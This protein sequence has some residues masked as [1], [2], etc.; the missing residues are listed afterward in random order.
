METLLTVD[1]LSV[2]FSTGDTMQQVTSNVS[3]DVKK[4]ETIGIVGESGS[5]KSVTAR[6]IMQLLAPNAHIHPESS[7][8]FMDKEL[9]TLTEKG[10]RDIRGNDIGMIF[11]DPMTSLNP[12]MTIGDQIT[13][14]LRYHEKLSKK[15]AEI[16]AKEI[17]EQVGITKVEERY[18]QYAHEFSGGMRQR[19]MI[20][21]ALACNPALLIADEPTTALDV[22]IQAQIL[23]LLKDIQKKFGTSII[24]IT[25]DFG[26]VANMC[27]RV[28]VMKEGQVVESGE[29]QT[30]FEHPKKDYTKM[31]LDAIPNLHKEKSGSHKTKL[32]EIRSGQRRKLL[33]VS[34]LNKFFSLG[35]KETLKAVNDI[36]FS[37]YEGETL[38]LVGESGSGKSTTGRTLLRLHEPT[39]GETIYEGFDLNNLSLGEMKTMRKHI[40]MIFQDPYASLNPRMKIID[41]I[42]EA[43]DVHRLAK[44]K[45]ERTERILELLDLVGLDKSFAQRYP[46][47][48][49]GGQ[50]QR[51]GIARA[52]A[53]DPEF[54]V[55]DEPLSALDAS[56]Q[57]QIVDLLEELQT[58][59]NLT[60]LFIAHDLAMVKQIS[61]RVAVMYNGQ[62]VE[63]AD[64]Q[65]LFDNPI[66]PY[67]RKLLSAIPVP[68]PQYE[69][70]HES[71]E[72]LDDEGFDLEKSRFIEISPHHWV[73]KEV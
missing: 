53:V 52:L 25:H 21:L 65:E 55:L 14:T 40:Q 6:S 39:S 23:N 49:S 68:D 57:I 33:E 13:E 26:V 70:T 46:H 28:I 30:V 61:D 5:G 19:M 66:H 60:Y 45:K 47:E 48:F 1:N 35:K 51:I 44:N 38:G 4:G 16:R 11:Q 71:I 15:K 18:S 59:F 32:A 34:R 9:L 20:A 56:I 42:G 10:M 41:I 43:I 31:L 12:T 54:I 67:T 36:S 2:S 7:I 63:L 64:A 22:T 29:T 17:M 62:I 8:A 3:F 50:R 58:K 24:V 73:A 27:D 37:I 69:A 72:Q